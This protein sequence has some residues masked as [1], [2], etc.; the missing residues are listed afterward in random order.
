MEY[1]LNQAPGCVSFF[2]NAS[3]ILQVTFSTRCNNT[4]IHF[5]CQ[6]YLDFIISYPSFIITL[7]PSNDY[8]ARYL[9]K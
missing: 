8:F 7:P 9:N 6:S 5:V 3:R 2:T 4:S 1:I